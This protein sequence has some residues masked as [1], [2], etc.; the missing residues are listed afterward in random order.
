MLPRR[1][2]RLL[3][4]LRSGSVKLRAI[5]VPRGDLI[6]AC[7]AV[8]FWSVGFDLDVSVRRL[9]KD[10]ENSHDDAVVVMQG[11]LSLK[12]YPGYI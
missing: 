12:S 2:S 7:T 8:A 11:C 10:T 5:S 4:G 6:A 9:M 3:I 1:K